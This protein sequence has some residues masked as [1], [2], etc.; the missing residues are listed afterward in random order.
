MEVLDELLVADDVDHAP[1]CVR[2]RT[3]LAAEP[4]GYD[5][6]PGVREIEPIAVEFDVEIAEQPRGREVHLVDPDGNRLRV[7]AS[8]QSG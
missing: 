5:D 2:V 3:E 1:A 6:L 4:R 7:G 8:A